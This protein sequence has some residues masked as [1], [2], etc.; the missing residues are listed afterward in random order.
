MS[1]GELLRGL[2]PLLAA[3]LELALVALAARDRGVAAARDRDLAAAARSRCRW[4]RSPA[5]SRR[6][7]ASR[8][9]R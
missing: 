5:W 9:S 4:S 7:R 2:P 8:C 3:H 6:S 1:L